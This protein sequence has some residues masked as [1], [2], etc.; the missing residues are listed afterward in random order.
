MQFPHKFIPAIYFDF[1]LF[2]PLKNTRIKHIQM[3]LEA[4][5]GVASL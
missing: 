5:L 2:A 4:V 1:N 3:K